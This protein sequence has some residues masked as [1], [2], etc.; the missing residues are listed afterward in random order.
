MG[1]FDDLVVLLLIGAQPGPGRNP[2]LVAT[3][4]HGLGEV[5]LALLHE[6]VANTAVTLLAEVDLAGAGS[7]I[8]LSTKVLGRTVW[9][10]GTE[11]QAG[12][13]IL[14]AQGPSQVPTQCEDLIRVAVLALLVGW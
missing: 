12:L 14:A 1:F 7:P 3:H 9:P 5:A 11:L 2:D 4:I 13:V 6:L 10:I 8:D